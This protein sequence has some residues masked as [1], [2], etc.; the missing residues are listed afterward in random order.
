MRI[1]RHI[2]PVTLGG[3]LYIPAIHK[4][5]MA[6][7]TR[8]RYPDLRSVIVCTEDSIL[9]S[10]LPQA[11]EAIGALLAALPEEQPLKIFLR[12]RSLALLEEMLTLPHIERV[13]GFVLPKFDT[14]NMG[15][16]LARLEPLAE[17]FY[18]LPVIESADMFKHEKLAA[19]RDTLI[20]SPCEVLTLRIGGEDMLKYFGLKRRCE[21]SLYDLVA[22]AADRVDHDGVQALRLQY[23]RPR[24]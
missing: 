14:G 4:N 19:I 21:D 13:D 23:R 3:T 15:T 9:E 18:I 11:M 22:C 7:C 8:N 2:D 1:Q 10:D 16:Y 5:L 12:P 24:L 17:S 20:A 6:V